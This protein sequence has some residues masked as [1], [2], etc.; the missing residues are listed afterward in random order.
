MGD[1]IENAEWELERQDRYDDRVVMI[2]FSVKHPVRKHKTVFFN[3]DGISIGDTSYE[4]DGRMYKTPEDVLAAMSG[5][6]LGVGDITW[7][8]FNTTPAFH[9]YVST[10]IGGIVKGVSRRDGSVIYGY[11]GKRINMDKLLD[12]INK[13]KWQGI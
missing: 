13:R 1:I 2:Y 5:K 10:N 11:H 8:L 6:R 4:Y 3:T 9:V 7:Q 12:I